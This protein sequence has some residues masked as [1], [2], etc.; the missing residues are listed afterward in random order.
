MNNTHI[1]AILD[2]S[3]DGIIAIDR[4]FNITLVNKNA[5]EILGLPNGIVGEKITKYIPQS[6]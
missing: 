3:H 6:D 5:T 2:A 1:Q 4:H